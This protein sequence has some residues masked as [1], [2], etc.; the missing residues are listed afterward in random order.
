M[1]IEELWRKGRVSFIIISLSF[2]YLMSFSWLKWGDLIVDVGR[3]MYVPLKLFEGKIL[4]RDIFYIYGPLSP[5]F[6]ALLFKIFGPHLYSL[7][8]S[9]ALTAALT[10]FFTYKV[11]RFFLSVFFSTFVTAAFLFVLA[12]GQ[13]VYFGNYN[14][15]LPYSYSSVH[16]AALSLG[17]L[18]LFFIWVKD[19]KYAWLCALFCALTLLSRLEMGLMLI[20]SI[21]ATLAAFSVDS[22]F[23]LVSRLCLACAVSAL[24]FILFLSGKTV[25]QKS[26]LDI[27]IKSTF[28]NFTFTG[29]LSGASAL[30]PNLIVLL[31]NILHYAALC[32]IFYA[33][34]YA[35]GLAKKVKPLF[36]RRCLFFLA[37][38]ISLGAGF[39]FYKRFF[40]YDLQFRG[41]PVICL[42]AGAVSLVKRK[43]GP[44]YLF[45]FTLSLFSLLL[46]S[47]VLLRVWAGHYGF[48]ILVPG[49][50]IYYAFF[51]RICADI[52]KAGTA[53][54]FFRSAFTFILV[55][56]IAGHFAV[57]RYCYNRRTLK[58]SSPKGSLYVFDNL[59]ERGLKDLLGFLDENTEKDE[60]LV[61]FPEG[62]TI[63]FL[64]GREN[65]LYYYSYH[66]VDLAV[67]EAEER[68]VSEM[69]ANKVDYVVLTQRMTEEY[70]YPVFGRD[71][72]AK[73]L[74]YVSENY[75]LYRQFGPF[76]FTS[77]EYGTALFKRVL[78][79][80]GA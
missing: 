25:L 37:A 31:K 68:V 70:G 47:R 64:S 50:I 5:Y 17:A 74:K 3:E 51:L 46:T 80:G 1:D 38:S 6:N 19:G 35:L 23:K 18:Y 10:A 75:V 44:E 21:L 33:G 71:Y 24:T 60:T 41:L 59:R 42:A 54:N 53:R 26:I 36:G 67:P 43:S 56:F 78:P 16:A 8:L 77:G 57:S 62:V 40:T 66:P 32:G 52:L 65:P 4:Y 28:P 27:W 69:R 39:L 63:N 12:F 22:W 76:P 11:S 20:F 72:A 73:I 9:G 29:W 45:I 2:L 55:L 14:F 7:F 61:V 34:G 79:E 30:K 13:Y 58:V 49:L 48:Y 15:I